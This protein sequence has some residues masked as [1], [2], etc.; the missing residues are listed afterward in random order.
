MDKIRTKT[1]APGGVCMY[2]YVC[3]CVC[4]GG[5]GGGEVYG[6]GERCVGGCVGEGG[7]RGEG[8]EGGGGVS[9]KGNYLAC[10]SPSP[11]SGIIQW[12]APEIS[13]ASPQYPL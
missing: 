8:G 10:L 2:V 7:G 1:R 3:V 12:M 5:G 6:C 9:T 4:G 13:E 11:T